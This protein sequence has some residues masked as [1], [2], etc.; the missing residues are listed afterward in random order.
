MA[1]GPTPLFECN[2]LSVSVAGRRL[3]HDLDFRARRGELLAILGQNGCGKTLTLHTLAGLRGAEAG[4]VRVNGIDVAIAGR[5]DIALQRLLI[6]KLGRIHH[7]DAL[8]PLIK[9]LSEEGN[10]S[11]L[12]KTEN[13]YM[14]EQ[15]KNMHLVTDDLYF[16][17]EEKLNSVELTEKGID[18]I[19]S[20][21]SG[22]PQGAVNI[23]YRN[24]IQAADDG[25]AERAARVG[26]YQE[27]FANPFVA[28]ERGY[29]DEVIVPRM[30]R[31]KLASAF[32][33]LQTKRDT[34]PAKKHGNIPL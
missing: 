7:E 14:Q 31:R 18:L 29:I 6:Q 3:V 23:L 12:L 10:K 2:S 27:K 26:A 20:P 1:E 28:A 33:M 15:S 19:D 9:L 5:K 11:L 17:I 13:H 8:K 4:R 32:A 30:L 25:E 21:V 22:G 24:E 34:M 16:I